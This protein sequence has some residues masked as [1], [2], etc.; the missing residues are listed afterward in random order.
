MVAAAGDQGQVVECLLDRGADI[1]RQ[2]PR[3]NR[4]GSTGDTALHRG[5]RAGALNAL[6]A[7]LE[8]G[9]DL[10]ISN[11]SGRLYAGGRGPGQGPVY[12]IWGAVRGFPQSF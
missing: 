9:A 10:H 2:T 3:S 8:R 1:D 4:M 6:E 7:L 11:D 12:G 5:A